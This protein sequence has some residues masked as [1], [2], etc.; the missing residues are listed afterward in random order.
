MVHLT[1]LRRRS[2]SLIRFSGEARTA[3][4][5]VSLRDYVTGA[6]RE[7]LERRYFF[8]T[9]PA[10]FDVSDGRKCRD[11]KIRGFTQRYGD[12]RPTGRVRKPR[13]PAL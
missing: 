8:S 10:G 2:S 9:G 11:A 1:R 12:H 7:K 6:L 4:E 3:E 13:H 5:G